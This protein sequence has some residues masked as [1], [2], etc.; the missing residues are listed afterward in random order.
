MNFTATRARSSHPETSRQAAQH[1]ASNQSA[2]NRHSIIQTVRLYTV[3]YETGWT[4]KEIAEYNDMDL[5]TVYRRL[6]ECA[7][8]KPHASLRRNGCRVWIRSDT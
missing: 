3:P 8:I 6:P 2:M 7:G 5:A 1:A 4:A